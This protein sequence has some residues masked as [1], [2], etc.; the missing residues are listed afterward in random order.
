[1]L[2]CLIGA[3]SSNQTLGA[4]ASSPTFGFI[5]VGARDDL[6]YNQAA[7]EGTEELARAY[8]EIHLLRQENVPETKAAETALEEMIHQG[9]TVLFATSFGHFDAAVTVAKRHPEVIV[10]HEGGVAPVPNLPNFGTFWGTV[11]E[12]EYLAGIVAGAASQAGKL[13]FVAAFPIPA[14]F[15]NIDAFQLGART[16]NPKVRTQVTF[17]GAWCDP[18]AQA[19]AADALVAAGV[20]VLTQHQDCTRTVLEKAEAAGITS[21]GYHEDGSE[22]ARKGWLVGS[23]WHWGPLFIEIAGTIRRGGFGD[24]PFH[25]DYRG[26]IRA[27][28]NPFV[29][30]E[31][32]SLVSAA[33][34]Q[35]VAAAQAWMAHG[36][37]PFEGPLRDREGVLRIE[38]GVMPAVAKLDKLRFL[39]EGVEGQ[40]PG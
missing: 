22:V 9:A 38:A 39:V 23:V 12:Q 13:G 2:L 25:G 10:L 18:G 5:F 27:G 33:T 14:T 40:L 28:G 29:L 20:D 30:T 31:F 21:I 26:G 34:R 35:R 7:W 19:E 1:M 3:C 16:V 32:S 24:S 11:Y 37:S 4:R 36:H 15:L 17:T 8:P 6:G